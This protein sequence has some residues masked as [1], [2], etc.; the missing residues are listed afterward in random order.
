MGEPKFTP[1]PWDWAAAQTFSANGGFHLYLTDNTGRKIAALW[2]KE[3][4]KIAN[5]KL[6]SAA[7][8]LLASLVELLEPL[9]CAS[10]ELVSHGKVADE[11]AEAA[12][13]RARAAIAKAQ[14]DAP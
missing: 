8:E 10:A 12:F 14:G 1:G 2:G 4:E 11:N 9:E 6:I 13:D 5:A 3:D 7:P